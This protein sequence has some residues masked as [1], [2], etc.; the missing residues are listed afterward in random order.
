MLILLQ[1]GRVTVQ[2]HLRSLPFSAVHELFPQRQAD[3][4]VVIYGV[5]G[6]VPA[7][8]EI[9]TRTNEFVSALRDYCLVSGIMMMSVP[10]V[11]RPLLRA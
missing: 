5:T 1:Y 11:K 6:G 9:F 2:I 8:L 7:Y 3:E 4:R 10:A